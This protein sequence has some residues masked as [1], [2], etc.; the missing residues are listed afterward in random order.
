MV[1]LIFICYLP[2]A[3]SL[4][5]KHLNEA[6]H[7]R[8]LGMGTGRTKQNTYCIFLENFDTA[9]WQIPTQLRELSPL[10]CVRKQK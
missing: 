4:S 5:T 7:A 6:L 3:L 2:S 9:D 10:Y 8:P 1:L